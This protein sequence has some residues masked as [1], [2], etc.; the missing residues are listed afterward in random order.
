MSRF[1]LKRPSPALVVATAALFVALGGT[2]YAAFQVMIERGDRIGGHPMPPAGRPLH[3]LLGSNPHA[4]VGA[5]LCVRCLWGGTAKDG[6]R[7]EMCG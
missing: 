1:R 2:G 4:L 6:F 7:Y 3:P 5:A